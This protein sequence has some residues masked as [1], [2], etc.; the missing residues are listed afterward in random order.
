[1]KSIYFKNFLKAII[2]VKLLVSVVRE[3]QQLTGRYETI[4]T[5]Y[6]LNEFL[7]EKRRTSG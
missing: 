1:M 3:F 2:D 5:V 4:Y 6:W 7:D